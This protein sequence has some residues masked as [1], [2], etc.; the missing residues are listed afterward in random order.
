MR[1]EYFL[2]T[3][4][5]DPEFKKYWDED[6]KL[7]NVD[8]NFNKNQ[9][10][11]LSIGEVLTLLQDIYL[12]IIKDKGIKKNIK[13][14]TDIIFFE[15]NNR[16][17]VVEFLLDIRD[18]KLMEK[19]LMNIAILAVERNNSRSS[20]KYISDGIF[21]LRSKQ[22]SNIT[23][24]FYFFVFGSSIILT[25]GYIKK[26]QK[27]AEKEFEKAKKYRNIYLRTKTR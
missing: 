22:S 1:F 2:T 17:P 27:L 8:I 25:N 16:C 24:I 5:A 18:K 6:V 26:D 9:Y 23:R 20:S 3:C 15:K 13:Y 11:E 10:E 14:S 12:D 19:I 21:E 4:L 7:S